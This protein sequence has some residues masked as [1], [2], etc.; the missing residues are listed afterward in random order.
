MVDTRQRDE[1]SIT[2][3]SVGY[4]PPAGREGSVE[5]WPLAAT[6]ERV[7]DAAAD[8]QRLDFH[9][10]IAVAEGRTEHVI[11]FERHTLRR[12]S[13]VWVRPG[14]THRWG[15][16]GAVDGYVVVFPDA[17]LDLR[18]R[19]LTASS[20]QYAPRT[21]QFDDDAATRLLAQFEALHALADAAEPSTFDRAAS[22]HLLAAVL[23]QLVGASPLPA[24]RPSAGFTR[25]RDAVEQ[26]H[27]R[28]HSVADYAALLG[29]SPRTL[30]RISRDAVDMSPK[31]L[32][33][34]RILLEAKRILV[35]S[36]L[37]AARVGATLGFDDSSNFGAWFTARAGETP[38]RFRRAAR[39][40]H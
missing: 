35:H 26:H 24:V 2:V 23:V 29:Y 27:A 39:G 17:A 22:E 8:P 34:D 18:V 37:S 15:E 6:A 21:W 9:L 1:T 25:L 11:D 33:D 40:H 36:D 13:I 12:G 5:A 32:I 28:L 14:V 38:D 4:H 31:Q 16:L 3:R 30:A 10:L 19:G 20:C 7:G